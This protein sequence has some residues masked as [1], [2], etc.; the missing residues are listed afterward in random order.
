MCD[1]RPKLIIFNPTF[2][3]LCPQRGKTSL[4]ESFEINVQKVL[5]T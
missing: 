2:A 5:L 3:W 1:S 4:T